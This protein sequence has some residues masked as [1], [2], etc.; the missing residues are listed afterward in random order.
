MIRSSFLNRRY[1]LHRKLKREKI[2]FSTNSKTIY[3][4][5]GIELNNQNILELQ[6]KHNY[7]IQFII[8]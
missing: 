8:Q 1:H 3:F 4:P 2:S 7:Q 5:V 6:K